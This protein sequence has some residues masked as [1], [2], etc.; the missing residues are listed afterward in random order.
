MSEINKLNLISSNILEI[1][2]WFNDD[3][4]SMDANIQNKCE[5]EVLAIIK[6]VAKLLSIDINIETEPI[7]EGGLKKWL[8]IVLKKE[9]KKGTITSSIVTTL[10]V[11][12]LTK[13][14]EKLSE[15][16]EMINLKKENLRLENEILYENKEMINLKNENLRLENEKL[17]E[18]KEINDLL[19]EK[20]ILENEDLKQN[21]GEYI[22]SIESS[23]YIKKRK[24]NFYETLEK[25]PKIEKISFSVVDKDKNIQAAEGFIEKKD[26]NNFILAS[27]NIETF[28]VE[29]DKIEIIAPVLKKQNYKWMGY[30]NDE[31][32]SFNMKS[33]EFKNSVENKEIEFI[34]GFSIECHLI[35]KQKINNE[36][37]VINYQYDVTRVNYYFKNDIPKETEEGKLYKYIKKG[38][39]NQLNLFKED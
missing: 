16:K 12:I 18:D 31:V 32:I 10:I 29:N 13:S 11:I 21:K 19:K 2:Y 17:Y 33:D 38:Q 4:H 5:Y 15:D 7:G 30:Y 37:I 25:Y 23:T 36:G 20:L 24:S 6:E 27:D 26:F 3:T 8:K 9:N 35:I 14:I 22:E 34:N 1:H 28:E 39:E